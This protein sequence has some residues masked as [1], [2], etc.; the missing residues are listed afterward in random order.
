MSAAL[1]EKPRLTA[2]DRCGILDTPPDP[3]FDRITRLAAQFFGVPMAAISFVAH[4]RSWFKSTYGLQQLQLARSASF[5]SHTINCPEALVIPDAAAD[6]RFAG[7]ALVAGHP[8]VR[9][10]AGVPVFTTG[11]FA[12]GAVAVM[13]TRPRGPLSKSEICTLHDFS[14]LISRELNARPS[15]GGG[16]AHDITPLKLAEAARLETENHLNLVQEAAG[17]GIWD[18]SLP[19]GSIT[20]SEQCCRIFGLPASQTT[21]SYVQWLSTVHPEDRDRVQAY[22]GNLLRGT[23]SLV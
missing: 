21:M 6:A 13:D 15:A 17:L 12:V 5:C 1:S 19:S 20:R 8:H 3:Y 2:L 10:Y 23:G 7:L 22:H 4:D 9:F 11:G 18:W 16:I 14:A